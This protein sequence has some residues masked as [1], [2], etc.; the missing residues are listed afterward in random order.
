VALKGGRYKVDA[1]QSYTNN[2]NHAVTVG[3]Q[4][5]GIIFASH[6]RAQN[7]Q[8]ILV[9]NGTLSFGAAISASERVACAIYDEDADAGSVTNAGWSDAAV[10]LNVFSGA[11]QA[12][13]DIVSIDSNG[14]TTV[15]D[16]V[17]PV[18]GRHVMYMAFGDAPSGDRHRL[19]VLGVG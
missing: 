5:K 14:F 9:S 12:A 15:M 4:P 16:T 18:A 6:N 17:E 2:S 19:P 10:Y 11:V 3:F 7:T 8:D 13:M 1:I